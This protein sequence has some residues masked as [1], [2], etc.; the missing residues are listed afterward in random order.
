LPR[1]LPVNFS[2]NEAN[3]IGQILEERAIPPSLLNETL[4]HVYI[5]DRITKQTCPSATAELLAHFFIPTVDNYADAGRVGSRARHHIVIEK[6]FS[7]LGR[8]WLPVKN[9][10][11]QIWSSSFDDVTFPKKLL[12]FERKLS[13]CCSVVPT[14]ISFGTIT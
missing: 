7:V 12:M 5:V 8:G 2:G 10:F 6:L 4:S 9:Y 1:R 14:H 3:S 11:S 13:C